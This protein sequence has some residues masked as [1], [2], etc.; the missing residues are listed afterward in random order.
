MSVLL[1]LAA[2]GKPSPP[3]PPPAAVRFDTDPFAGWA[4][5]DEGAAVE[6]RIERG[7]LTLE[8]RA[9][10]AR[11]SATLITLAVRTRMT[12]GGN[13][14]AVESTEELRPAPATCAVCDRG[15]DAHATGAWTSEKLGERACSVYA[16]PAKDC[17]GE[18]P[19]ATKTWFCAEVPGHVAAMETPTSR[20]SLVDFKR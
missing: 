1:A 5:F 2:C 8:R 4:S 18:P 16:W 9:T 3:A 19:A 7:G 6:H 17:R 14:R 20:W 13:E 11:K 15:R 12:V 10:L